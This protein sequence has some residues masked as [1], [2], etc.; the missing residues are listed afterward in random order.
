MAI[1]R[2][3]SVGLA[4][5]CQHERQAHEIQEGSSM[6][7]NRF[8]K[9]T[10]MILTS[11]FVASIAMPIT[12]ASAHDRHNISKHY[13][14]GTPLTKNGH[15]K[16]HKRY[17]R[18][19]QGRVNYLHESHHHHTY[20][21]PQPRVVYKKKRRSNGDLVAAGIIGLTLGAIIASESAKNRNHQPSYQYSDPYQGSYHGNSRHIPL[22]EYD[23]PGS[24]VSQYD[25]GPNVITYDDDYCPSSWVS[26]QTAA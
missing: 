25:N 17:G 14:Y 13:G 8:F 18:G 7:S 12:A 9:F 24:S 10:S 16:F 1:Q 2:T 22:Q 6:S 4:L 21:A 15:R 19:H 26:G 5:F 20:I 23:E 11:T 3:F